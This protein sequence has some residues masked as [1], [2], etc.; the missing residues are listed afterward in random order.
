MP[1]SYRLRE[2]S[3][4]SYVKNGQNAKNRFLHMYSTLKC[5]DGIGAKPMGFGEIRAWRSFESFIAKVLLK[6][7][8]K[9][10][11]LNLGQNCHFTFIKPIT[12]LS[13]EIEVK[14]RNQ[15]KPYEILQNQASKIIKLFSS[16]SL[17]DLVLEIFHIELRLKM[18]KVTFLTPLYHLSVKSIEGIWSNPLASME[19]KQQRAKKF[20]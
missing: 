14:R 6:Y 1:I 8:W 12:C 9:Q 16:R 15:T 18:A 3:C 4:Q 17:G 7:P 10:L 11:S 2:R 13:L 5:V 20:F 19:S